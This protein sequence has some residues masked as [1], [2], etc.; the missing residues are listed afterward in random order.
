MCS[1]GHIH[2]FECAECARC[3]SDAAKALAAKIKRDKI[4]EDVKAFVPLSP[5]SN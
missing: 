1:V 3:I 5:Q 2:M 4:V